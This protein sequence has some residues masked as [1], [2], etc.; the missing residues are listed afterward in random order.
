[1]IRF[2]LGFLINIIVFVLL[3]Y[4]S[5]L[6]I[7]LKGIENDAKYSMYDYIPGLIFQILL[8]CIIGY[9]EKLKKNISLTSLLMY[10]LLIITTLLLF[11][12][13]HLR[14]IPHSIVPY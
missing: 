7:F 10:I 3:R 8:I 11:I 9:I 12:G 2:V 4:F 1:M 5:I 6:F 14:L 13:S